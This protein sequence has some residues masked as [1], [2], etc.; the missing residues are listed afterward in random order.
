MRNLLRSIKVVLTYTGIL[1]S[2]Y[3]FSLFSRPY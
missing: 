2:T 1:I 3:T